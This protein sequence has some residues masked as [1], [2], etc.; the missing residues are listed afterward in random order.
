MTKVY[1]KLA[2]MDGFDFKTGNS[3]NYAENI[4]KTVVVPNYNRKEKPVLCTNTVLHACLNAN[5]CF[6]G[7]KLPCRVFQVTGYP[8]VSDGSKSGFRKLRVIGEIAQESLDTFF[9]WRYSETINPIHPFKLQAP[10]ITDVQ[11]MLL[12]TWASVWASV[13][14]SVGASVGAS[15]GA[16]VGASVWDS[17]WASVRA[18]VWAYIGSMFPSTKTWKYAPTNI[19]GYPYQSCVDLWRQGIVPSF[20]G[21]TWRLHTNLD[22]RIAYEISAEKLWSWKQ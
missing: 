2:R 17:V 1:Y 12:Q 21:S 15:F 16:S 22:A 3:V 9:G 6:I 18:S 19:T 8:V 13:R 5:D 14:A 7:A 11:I 10:Q 20:D 4:G